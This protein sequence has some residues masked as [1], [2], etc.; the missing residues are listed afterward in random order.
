MEDIEYHI[1]DPDQ[2]IIVQ[3]VQNGYKII[4]FGNDPE[5]RII[6]E[7]VYEDTHIAFPEP[8]WENVSNLLWNIL[9]ELGVH[10]SKHCKGGIDIVTRC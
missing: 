8:C 5:D 1:N 7:S 4:S 9:E 3:R 2:T 10:N 6:V